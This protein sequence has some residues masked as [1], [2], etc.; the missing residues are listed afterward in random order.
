MSNVSSLRCSEENLQLGANDDLAV[1][2]ADVATEA[3]DI[4]RRAVDTNT[5]VDRVDADADVGGPLG[6]VA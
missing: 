6:V 4:G 2:V 3:G 5:C 1:V